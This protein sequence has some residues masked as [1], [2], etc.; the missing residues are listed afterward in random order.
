MIDAQ[1][2]FKIKIITIHERHYIVD[3]KIITSNNNNIIKY[4]LDLL[5]HIGVDKE[6]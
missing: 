5:E 3:D 4:A 2:W 6:H 1:T